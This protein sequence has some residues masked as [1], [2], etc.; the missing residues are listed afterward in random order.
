MKSLALSLLL[1]SGLF[2]GACSSPGG[3]TD[4]APSVSDDE[5]RSV[6]R[7]FFI[8]EPVSNPSVEALRKDLATFDAGYRWVRNQGGVVALQWESGEPAAMT[9]R[10][11]EALVQAAFAFYVE[12]DTSPNRR[13]LEDLSKSD[14]TRGALDDALAKIG[15]TVDSPDA[16]TE[17][18]HAALLDALYDVARVP[19]IT[20]YTAKLTYEPDMYWEGAVLVIDEAN[21][22]VLIATGGY[23][24]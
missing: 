4:P 19:A 16:K 20:V 21:K 3:A 18:A 2:L 11:R 22:Q 10:Q 5:L 12:R 23:G 1:S 14:A 24:T 8:R 6:V 13:Y 9:A 17:A 15:L 7:S